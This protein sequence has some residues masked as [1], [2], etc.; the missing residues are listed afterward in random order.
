MFDRRQIWKI[1]LFVGISVLIIVLPFW[2]PESDNPLPFWVSEKEESKNQDSYFKEANY[3]LI[4]GGRPSFQL[5]ADELITNAA[6]QTYLYNPRGRAY[7]EDL[8]LFFYEGKRGLYNPAENFLFLQDA[9]QLKMENG[10]LKADRVTY[11][12]ARDI[13]T[14]NGKVQTQNYFDKTGDELYINSAKLVSYPGKKISIYSQD[15]DGLIKRKRVYEPSVKFL[16][17]NLYLDHTNYLAQL[18]GNVQIERQ[19][20]LAT[21]LR[22]EIFLENY[23]KRLKYYIL[24]DDVKV[25]EKL[26][27]KNGSLVERRAYGEKLEGI[28]SEDRIILTGYPRVFQEHDEVKGNRIVL[29]E[30]NEVVEVDDATTNFLLK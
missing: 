11:Q 26:K 24:Y 13:V 2:S 27:L 3:F 30:N 25:K 14:A 12:M 23:S 15:V 8:R 5:M 7:T 18:N 16:T 28:V 22:G 17:N 9:V 4:D 20:F 10:I 19:N 1:A 21:S 6:Q 29:R